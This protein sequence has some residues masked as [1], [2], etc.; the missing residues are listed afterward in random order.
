MKKRLR[1]FV[2]LITGCLVFAGI[3]CVI[4][5]FYYRDSF[6]VNTWI[7]GV[8]CTGKTLEEINSQLAE[9]TT[10]SQIVIS[11]LVDGEVTEVVIPG[12]VF[13]VKAD[14][15]SVLQKYLHK[16]TGVK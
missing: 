11:Y 15:S 5:D 2:G 7:N 14:Y 10:E 13:S 1:I 4:L 3:M 9:Q 8:Y 16:E 6:P 12:E